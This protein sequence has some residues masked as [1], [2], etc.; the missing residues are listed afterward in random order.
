M[1]KAY[2]VFYINNVVYSINEYTGIP[3][4]MLD[5]IHQ[6]NLKGDI[7]FDT[8]IAASNSEEALEKWKI[9]TGNKEIVFL[10]L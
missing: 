9:L 10:L 2:R 3:Q 7:Y 5:R 1:F 4:I 6:T 8:F